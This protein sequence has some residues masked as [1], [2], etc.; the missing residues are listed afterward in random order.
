VHG[1]LLHVQRQLESLYALDE[2]P[3]VTDF[4]MA[5][6]AARGYPGGGSRTL[7]TQ[8]DDEL[9]LAV[10]LADSVTAALDG[11]DPRERLHRR[12]LGPFC[13]LIEEV[14]HFVFLLFCARVARTVTQ[15]ELELQAEVDKY[16]AALSLLALQ[17][18][19][20][21]SARLK[22]LLFHDYHLVAGLSEERAERYHAVSGL[23]YRYCRWLER[24]Y[25]RPSRLDDLR[26][27]ARRFYRLGQAGKLER[28]SSAVRA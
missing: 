27:E 12:N 19:G 28:I 1:L 21:L 24:E 22:E 14:S 7:I 9:S 3:P 11:D 16:L 26:R 23:A 15:L 13:T 6:Q 2:Q 4:L 20:A 25:L 5:E 18:E 10:V 8:Q 17:N